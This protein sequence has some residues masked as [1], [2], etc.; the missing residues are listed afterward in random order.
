MRVSF[1]SV[2]V[3]YG[4][5]L[6]KRLTIYKIH[7]SPQ[8]GVQIDNPSHSY[9]HLESFGYLQITENADEFRKNIPLSL[10]LKRTHPMCFTMQNDIDLVEEKHS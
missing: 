7:L 1:V 8:K 10:I 6:E 2:P 5:R 9:C 3:F 4:L